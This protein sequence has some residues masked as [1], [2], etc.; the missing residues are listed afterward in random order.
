[1]GR[2]DITVRK[3]QA[4]DALATAGATSP[5]TAA[6]VQTLIT[7]GLLNGAPHGWGST[8]SA[9]ASPR[10]WEGERTLVK[11]A[12]HDARQWHSLWYLV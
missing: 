5:T 8:L 11:C 10:W 1:M 6:S 4:L 7:L 9:L 12:G 3:Q 2:G